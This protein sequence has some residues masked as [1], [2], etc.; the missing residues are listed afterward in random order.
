[1]GAGVW[2]F[3]DSTAKANPLVICPCTKFGRLWVGGIEGWAINDLLGVVNNKAMQ[4][5][6]DDIFPLIDAWKAFHGYPTQIPPTPQP[7]WGL[8][9]PQPFISGRITSEWTVIRPE[10]CQALGKTLPQV[11]FVRT[12]RPILQQAADFNCIEALPH[13]EN[14]VPALLKQ[15]PAGRPQSARGEKIQQMQRSFGLS[16]FL[17]SGCLVRLEN[18]RILLIQQSGLNT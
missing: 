17:S 6:A 7:S 12:N 15:T 4:F 11:D 8:S 1:L 9:A 2:W 14:Y 3:T 13:G 10:Q 5:M 18:P 16:Q